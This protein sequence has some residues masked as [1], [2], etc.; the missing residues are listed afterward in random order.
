MVADLMPP[1]G[2]ENADLDTWTL[3]K[4]E[5]LFRCFQTSRGLEQAIYF[6]RCIEH[7]GRFGDLSEER[8][9]CYMGTSLDACIVETIM[10][11][12]PEITEYPSDDLGSLSLANIC[13]NRDLKLVAMYGSSLVKN[14]ADA[15]VTTMD[16]NVSRAWSTSIMNNPNNYDGIIWRS[17]VNNDLMSVVIFERCYDHLHVLPAA[18][19]FLSTYQYGA[20]CKVLDEHNIVLI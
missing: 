6:A 12:N 5:M 16:H 18:D 14:S 13:F 4:G 15:S 7:S 11:D 9:V 1:A 20:V 3:N 19:T 8:G 17:R 2:Y 10:H